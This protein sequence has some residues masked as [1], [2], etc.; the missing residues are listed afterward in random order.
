MPDYVPAASFIFECI[1]ALIAFGLPVGLGVWICR[2]HKGAGHAILI[3]AFCFIVSVSVLEQ[4]LHALVLS[5]CPGLTQNAAAFTLYGCLAAGVF[6]ETARL[7]GLRSLCKKDPAAATGFAYGVGHGGA[8][9]VLLVGMGLVSNL[10]VMYMLNSGQGASLVENFTGEELAL[11]QQQLTTLAQTPPLTFLAAGIE[12]AYS[13]AFHI[14]MSMLVWMTVVKRLP[15]WG[16][17]AAIGMHALV[18]VPAMLYQTGVLGNIWLAEALGVALCAA[19]VTC[20]WQL[21]RRTAQ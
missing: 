1:S 18:N 20:V 13:L 4:I 2:S 5:L 7:L 11:A 9:A 8:E 3:G 16:Y 10:M 17:A 19:A 21:Y 14:A 12:R 6:E 15:M